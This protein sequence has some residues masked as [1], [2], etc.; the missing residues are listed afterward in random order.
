MIDGEIRYE[1]VGPRFR[2]LR[3][4]LG[5]NQKELSEALDLNQAILS[6]FE[7]GGMVYARVL[8]DVMDFFREK[9][10]LNYLLQ[11]GDE[12]SLDD[13]RAFMVT[14]KQKNEYVKSIAETELHNLNELLSKTK[15]QV[16][17]IINRAGN[18]LVSEGEL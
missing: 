2:L 15:Q 3:E 8:L 16:E 6:K 7:N 1:Q 13:P 10:N 14:K 11:P 4:R 18:K 17:E 9:V 12:F 5:I